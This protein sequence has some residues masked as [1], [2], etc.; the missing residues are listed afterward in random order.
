LWKISPSLGFDPRNYL[1]FG[2]LKD[3]IKEEDLEAAGKE[4]WTRKLK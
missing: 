3:D 4:R 2:A 1:W